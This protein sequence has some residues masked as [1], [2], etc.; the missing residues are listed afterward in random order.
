MPR[1][2]KQKKRSEW[3]PET[4]GERK[5]VAKRLKRARIGHEQDES[6]IQKHTKAFRRKKKK[7]KL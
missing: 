2:R 3:H 6:W 1:K 7:R 5:G 4:E